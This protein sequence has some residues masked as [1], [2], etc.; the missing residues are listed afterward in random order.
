MQDTYQTI[1]HFS[2]FVTTSSS[3]TQNVVYCYH[4]NIEFK[5]SWYIS[6][7]GKK[8]NAKENS[9]FEL[10]G[11][12]R[13]RFNRRQWTVRQRRRHA[14]DDWSTTTLEAGGGRESAASFEKNS[15]RV[16]QFENLTDFMTSVQLI[17]KA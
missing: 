16:S 5:D 7:S 17:T 11:N 12:E 10:T 6:S 14:T 15:K 2:G 8:Q 3:F 9:F 1:L 13:W 4:R